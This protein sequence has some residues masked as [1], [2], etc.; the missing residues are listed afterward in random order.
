MFGYV[1]FLNIMLYDGGSP[2]ANY[3]WTIDNVNQWKSR[4]LPADKA[5]LGVPFYSRPAY[6]SYAQLVAM[7]PANAYRD[8]TTVN[9]TQTC[10]N[11][12]PDHSAQDPVGP[13]QRRR[14]DELGTLPGHHHHAVARQRD[15]RDRRRRAIGRDHRA[16]REVRRRV[17]GAGRE[18]D[19]DPAVHLQRLRR[20][21]VDIAGRRDGARPGSVSGCARGSTASGT[22]VQ[23]W[24]CHGGANQVWQSRADGTLWNP[25][26]NKCLDAPGW[27]SADGTR[28]Q[29][30]DC[31]GG[32]NQA[33]HMR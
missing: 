9:G 29:I 23:L 15:R 2:H 22:P 1:D 17:L 24:D 10:Y 7:D 3:D 18:R 21:V 4:G 25:L 27:S 19:A 30:W 14:N 26:S 16:R 11:G 28:L 5:V 12:L 33:W 20:A 32:T 8:C 6:Y 13:G 31:N